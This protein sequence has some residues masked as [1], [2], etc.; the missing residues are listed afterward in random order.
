MKFVI[1]KTTGGLNTASFGYH[2]DWDKPWPEVDYV[3]AFKKENDLD[4]V[5]AT[6]EEFFRKQRSWTLSPKKDCRRDA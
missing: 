1:E 3:K 6:H 2:I 5:S 4:P